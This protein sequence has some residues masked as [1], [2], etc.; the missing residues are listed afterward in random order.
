MKYLLDV[1]ALIALAVV[2]HAFHK[3][4]LR[5]ADGVLQNSDTALLTCSISELGFIRVLVQG[6]GMSIEV[7]RDALGR[8]K[9]SRLSAFAFVTDDHDAERLPAWVKMGG[10]IT[11]GHLL[12]LAEAHGAKLATLDQGIPGAFLIPLAAAIST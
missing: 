2:D 9:R 7:S 12:E 10:Q 3:R 4:V 1:N 8:L 6:Y 11:D 5:W